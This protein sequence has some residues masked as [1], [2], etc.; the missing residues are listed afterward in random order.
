MK[1]T[2]KERHALCFA[3]VVLENEHGLSVSDLHRENCAASIALVKRLIGVAYATARESVV[4]AYREL[5]GAEPSEAF[6]EQAARRLMEI[7]VRQ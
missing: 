6:I 7:E 3:R 5:H 4:A 1:F 2:E